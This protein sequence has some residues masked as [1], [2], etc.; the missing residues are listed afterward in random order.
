MQD[1]YE[2]QKA[3]I[4]ITFTSKQDADGKNIKA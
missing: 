4:Y 3:L 1:S 2:K